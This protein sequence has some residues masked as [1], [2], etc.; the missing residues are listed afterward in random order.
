MNRI[1]RLFAIATQ[2]QARHHI[3][4]V[5]LA[6]LFEVSLRTIYRDVAALSESGIPVVSLP[7]Q[8]YAL[9]DGYFLKPLR[10]TTQEATALVLGARLL[11]GSASPDLAHSADSAVAKILA[12]IGDEPRRQLQEIENAIELNIATSSPDRLDL[13]DERVVTLRHAILDRRVIS[14]R[15][16]GRNRAEETIRKVEPLRLGYMNGA[17]YLAAYCQLRQEERAFRL[18]R[19]EDFYV[20][21]TRFWRRPR[22]HDASRQTVEVIVRFRSTAARWAQERQHWSFTGATQTDGYLTATYR[23]DNLDEIAT[24]ILGWGTDAEVLSPPLLRDRIKSEASGI[25]QML[26]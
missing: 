12:I 4:A 8:G 18:D 19:I 25:V 5:D 2:L 23:P 14:L 10:L 7:G 9:A 13:D 6:N 20:E 21:P 24:W 22:A 3:R 16:F 15:Y 1:D 11:S 26:T 17:W